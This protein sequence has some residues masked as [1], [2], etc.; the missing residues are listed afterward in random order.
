M[1]RNSFSR[2]GNFLFRYRSF[3]P[4]LLLVPGWLLFVHV[5]QQQLLPDWIPY[6][7]IVYSSL[8]VSV[9][10]LAIRIVAV[11][12]TPAHTSGRNTKMQVAEELNTTG[13][14]SIVRHPLYLGNFFM[15][16]GSVMLVS[17]GWFMLVFALAYWLYYERIMYAEEQFLTSK[18]GDV[19]V[20]WATKVPAFIPALRQPVR[21]AYP[22]SIK[23]VVKK[24]KNGILAIFTL[25]FVFHNTELSV[26]EENFQIENNWLLWALI[27]ST[28]MYL[29]LKILKKYTSLLDEK[30]R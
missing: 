10:G 13:I 28:V 20:Q 11:G 17:H 8:V 14:Y 7:C 18:F 1:L 27:L 21:P 2:E 23:K 9:I 12:Y 4:L 16:L 22:F 30:G 24:E 25:L 3:L 5:V 29:I 15:W 26:R 19:Y 6:H